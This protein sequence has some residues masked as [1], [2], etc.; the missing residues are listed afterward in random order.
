[1]AATR[2]TMST[3]WAW[4][5]KIQPTVNSVF[6]WL[7]FGKC[8]RQSHI[9]TVYCTYQSS[10]SNPV[11]LGLPLH[12]SHRNAEEENDSEG[13][14]NADVVKFICHKGIYTLLSKTTGSM[15]NKNPV[16]YFIHFIKNKERT[17]YVLHDP[18]NYC[19]TNPL[20]TVSICAFLCIIIWS[21]IWITYIKELYNSFSKAYNIHCHCNCIGKCK[22]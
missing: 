12:A 15:L 22:Y 6:L 19:N 14:D 2:M 7:T 20:V 21:R 8:Q 17:K 9:D 11:Y 3:I 13:A 18:V 4:G 16:S 5:R 1:M 10:N